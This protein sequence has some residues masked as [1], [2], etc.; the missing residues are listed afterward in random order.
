[1]KMTVI[2]SQRYRNDEI[3]EKKIDSLVAN[4]ETVVVVPVV[5]AYIKDLE[6]N[7]LYIMVD[8]HH[9]LEAAREL[10]LN[11]K[12]EEVEDDLA[13]YEDIEKHNGEAICEAHW[14]DSNW[15][16]INCMNEDMIG[17]DVW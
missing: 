12:F 2:S 7:E 5:R 3:V 14:M 4:G 11:V 6:G 15:Y 8:K 13:Y 1:M 10:G 9:T 17:V 16:Y